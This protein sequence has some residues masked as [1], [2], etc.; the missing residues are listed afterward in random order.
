MK[1]YALTTGS[2]TPK[3]TEHADLVR[4]QA[5]ECVVILE[6]DGILPL[7]K[8]GKIALFGSGARHTVK[9]GTGSGDVYSRSVTS[10]E[11]GLLNAGF[12]ITTT[13][14]LDRYDA[15]LAEHDR[16][17]C[18]KCEKIAK[19]KGIDP[20]M[21]MFETPIGNPVLPLVT[22]EDRTDCDT[23][24]F[25]ISRDSGEFKDRK[26]ERGDYLLS[27]EEIKCLQEITTYYPGTI[28][29]L[30]G[31]GIIDLTEVLGA[32]K[33]SALV[34]ASQLGNIGGDVVADVLLG[35]SDPSGR[36]SDTWAYKYEDYPCYQDFSHNN[37]NVDDEYY[38]EGIYI[39]YR[40]F[41]SFDIAPRYPFG[42]GLGYT[43]FDRKV[44]DVKLQGSVV[45]IKVEVTNT[46]K[47]RGKEVVQVYVSAPEGRIDKPFQELR[48][49]GKT[50]LIEPGS[51][52]EITVSFDMRDAAGYD[53]SSSSMIL[54]KGEYLV[55]VGKDSR[56]TSVAAV[57]T[58]EEDITVSVLKN[59]FAMDHEFEELNNPGKHRRAS[60]AAEMESAVRLTLD[61]SS[62]TT[63]YADY[64]DKRKVFTDN[65]SDEF[66]TF[67]DVLSGKA[68]VEELT[69]QLTVEQ[70]ATLCVG[71]FEAGK[72]LK[73][74]V[75]GQASLLVP[76][77]AAE[78]P[79]MADRKIP[80]TILADGPA[81]LRLQPHF[82]ATAD[83]RRLVGGATF[84]RSVEPFPED[85]PADAVDY[86]QYCTAIPIATALAQTW[87]MDLIYNM[88][89][90]V[91]EEMKQY[92][93]HF[94]LAPGMNIHRN[95]LCG[96]NFEYYSEDP[97][98]S[99]HCAAA[100]TEGVQSFGGQ[101]TTIK[102]F[103]CNNQEENRMFSNSHVSEKALRELYLKGFEIAVKKSQ[104]I[105]VMTSY[106]LLNG[107][108]AANNYDLIQNVLRDEWGFEGVVMSDW[109]TS[110]DVGFM[111]Y[112][113]SKYP[114]SSSVDCIISGNDWQMPGCQKNIDD[115]IDAVGDGSLPLSDLMFCTANILRTTVRCFS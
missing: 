83:G 34:N 50:S 7:E 91:G 70:M 33:I 12:E 61:G 99:G 53:V 95:P 107:I 26:Y 68:T 79:E 39:G 105:S 44:K 75:V 41:D 16:L 47:H 20:M 10:I 93:V 3:E 45:S 29:L 54:E 31:G 74:S 98:L 48:G 22:E 18:E 113:P 24:I 87:N 14:W 89:K 21:V 8:P 77:A 64:S 104:P 108:H 85:T 11:Q 82:K 92:Y 62:I 69:A 97:F 1:Y 63:E 23:A 72:L 42:Y 52:D 94:W 6:N 25:V 9:G 73:D 55:R 36:L 28:I 15:A 80:R 66:L 37:G 103:A 109:F 59:L 67:D 60:D 17:Y 76:G 40:Y 115:I 2:V 5:G 112:A 13:S 49:F 30:N 106:N 58:I 19:E 57:V 43:T 51:S 56:S 46:G 65:R 86:Y 27:E 114:I 71:S 88:G 38:K 4:K 35:K 110:Q 96:R 81:G 84:G 101:G 90:I 32:G 111:G 102:H 100:D 78:S